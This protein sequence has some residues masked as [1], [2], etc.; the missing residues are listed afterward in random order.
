MQ[1]LLLSARIDAMAARIDALLAEAWAERGIEPAGP[2]TDSRGLR[3][4]FLDLVGRIPRGTE[5]RDEASARFDRQRPASHLFVLHGHEMTVDTRLD[6]WPRAFERFPEYRPR[7]PQPAVDDARVRGGV[8]LNKTTDITIK[9]HQDTS[10]ESAHRDEFSVCG[11]RHR[12]TGLDYVVPVFSKPVK[13][14]TIDVFVGE[15]SHRHAAEVG[16]SNTSSVAS[17]S[18]AHDWHA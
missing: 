1:R 16:M 13:N 12:N 5:A 15:D 3:R 8:G 18:A 10:L 6:Q 7:A 14:R 4:V 2:A 17:I 9:S 11:F